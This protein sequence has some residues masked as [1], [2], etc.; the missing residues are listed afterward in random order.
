VHSFRS[1]T[2]AA[3]LLVLVA[4][5]VIFPTGS[6]ADT[7]DAAKPTAARTLAGHLE[8]QVLVAPRTYPAPERDEGP[9]PALFYERMPYR[10]KATRVFAYVGVPQMEGTA[11][12]PG[13]VLVHGG[14]GTAFV[15]WVRIW[16]RRGYAAIAMDLEGHV[17][18]KGNQHLSH[19]HG[20][21]ARDGIFA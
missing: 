4:A 14:G 11:K 8:P 6:L 7:P 18:G 2:L 9:V 10:G 15:E 12:V 13:M 19:E 21:P 16:N 1:L 20:G 17:P 5:C 3:R